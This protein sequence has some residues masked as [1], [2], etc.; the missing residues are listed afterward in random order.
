MFLKQEFLGFPDLEAAFEAVRGLVFGPLNPGYIKHKFNEIVREKKLELEFESNPLS[1]LAHVREETKERDRK[2]RDYQN[3]TLTALLATNAAYRAMHEEIMAQLP[4]TENLLDDN[5]DELDEIVARETKAL[6]AY[7][8]IHAAK[9][10]DGRFVFK[11]GKDAQGNDLFVD[12]SD[13]P[14]TPEDAASIDFTG[15]ISAAEYRERRKPL[16]D[17]IERAGHNRRD[18]VRVGE[19]RERNTDQD[20]PLSM[21][22]KEADKTELGEIK[23]RAQENHTY[24]ERKMSVS[25]TVDPKKEEQH[26]VST[27]TMAAPQL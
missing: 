14:V 27:A 5:Q 15:K 12:E 25:A 18:R 8:E 7:L 11:V 26:S 21:E 19:I 3:L 16:D 17:A 20:N 1:P 23:E 9:L 10:P 24:V 2:G 4:E 22:Q 6:R 13:N